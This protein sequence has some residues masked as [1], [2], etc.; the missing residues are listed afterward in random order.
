[1]TSS[2]ESSPLILLCQAYLCLQL[3]RCPDAVRKLNQ[4]SKDFL[5]H[6]MKLNAKFVVDQEKVETTP[7]GKVIAKNQE[8]CFM[9]FVT[10]S[11]IEG[12]LG[13]EQLCTVLKLSTTLAENT[14][15]KQFLEK[16]ILGHIPVP[17][18]D[19]DC[20]EKAVLLLTE[21]LVSRALTEDVTVPAESNVP[22][23][24][25]SSSSSSVMF[26][27]RH[28][29]LDSIIP[30]DSIYSTPDAKELESLL[31]SC[32]INPE[33]ARCVNTLLDRMGK[34]AIETLQLCL[35]TW[36]HLGKLEEATKLVLTVCPSIAVD[37]CLTYFGSE[38]TRWK[39]LLGILLGEIQQAT[40]TK[41][42]MYSSL[43][44]RS[45]DYVVT[46]TTVEE[47]VGLLPQ[48]GSLSFFL[49]LL[50]HSCKLFMSRQISR[51]LQCDLI[52]A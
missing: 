7:L 3:Q 16:V 12:Q 46:I 51:Q 33:V 25:S 23:S 27:A 48:N 6:W 45:L 8:S 42:T 36:P 52:S 50:E 19:S 1:M 14:V 47:F 41:A 15:L 24:S 4:V 10:H 30:S 35:L 11:A 5:T 22:S 31:C 39:W 32:H 21:L 18:W 29:W 34:E 43:L 40:P 2:I 28:K 38:L 13:F 17:T 20:T 49:P 37:F 44:R 9:E 26:G